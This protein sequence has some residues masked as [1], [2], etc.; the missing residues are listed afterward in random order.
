[1]RVFIQLRGAIPAV[2][3]ITSV[4]LVH[5]FPRYLQTID[6]CNKEINFHRT[7][8][9][10]NRNQVPKHYQQFFLGRIA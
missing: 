5:N 1:M 7:L 9:I 8:L 10:V 6:D 4:H 3:E 2:L